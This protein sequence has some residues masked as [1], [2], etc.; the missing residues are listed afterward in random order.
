MEPHVHDADA[1]TDDELTALGLPADPDQPVEPDAVPIALDGAA[2]ALLPEWY[3]PAPMSGR[4]WC[5]A[6][7][8]AQRDRPPPRGD[9]RRR[10]V[11][12]VRLP[13]DRLVTHWLLR[14]MKSSANSAAATANQRLARLD[15]VQ[16]DQHGAEPVDVRNGEERPRL[17]GE[18]GLLLAEV[19]DAYSKDRPGGRALLAEW[20]DICLAE[21]PLP[22]ERL[23][24]DEPGPIART[25]PAGTRR[26]SRRV[27]STAAAVKSPECKKAGWGTR[28]RRP[29]FG[30]RRSRSS[31]CGGV[32]HGGRRSGWT[33]S[34]ECQ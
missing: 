12:H 22:D 7:V 16:L 5:G 21:R 11:R 24:G 18:N 19:L 28:R 30:G 31:F 10:R 2:A 1:I 15:R 23:A 13:R 29:A 4:K 26:S 17:G 32:R 6:A 9:Q 8:A 27:R 14:S 33:S 34:S 20:P 25:V 3:M